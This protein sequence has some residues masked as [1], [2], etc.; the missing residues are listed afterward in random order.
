MHFKY[1][2]HKNIDFLMAEQIIAKAEKDKQTSDTF[3]NN[4]NGGG[5][6]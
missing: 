6:V 1:T 5:I 2:L 4:N 3:N